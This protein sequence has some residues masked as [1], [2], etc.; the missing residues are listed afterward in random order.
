MHSLVVA[1]RVPQGA[2]VC[3]RETQVKELAQGDGGSTGLGTRPRNLRPVLCDAP[4]CPGGREQVRLAKSRDRPHE[5]SAAWAEGPVTLGS[6]ARPTGSP[7]EAGG[8]AGEGTGP[9]SEPWC[10][11]PHYLDSK[12]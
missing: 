4:L 11:L 7:R 2:A 6:L 5:W 10:P 1:A 3:S 12:C 9:T 8:L